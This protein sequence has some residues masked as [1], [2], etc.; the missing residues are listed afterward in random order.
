MK[1]EEIVELVKAEVAKQLAKQR[2]DESGNNGP[3]PPPPPGG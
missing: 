1:R 3:P 2:A